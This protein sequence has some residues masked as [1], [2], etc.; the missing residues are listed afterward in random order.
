MCVTKIC[1]EENI[2]FFFFVMPYI[3]A[4]QQKVMHFT[5]NSQHCILNA[6]WLSSFLNKS[7]C[8]P[9]SYKLFAVMKHNFRCFQHNEMYIIVIKSE[10]K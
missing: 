8:S 9:L 6:K 4:L 2:T 5:E 7:F 10:E 3:T 1:T